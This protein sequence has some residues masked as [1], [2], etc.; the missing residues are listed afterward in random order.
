MGIKSNDKSRV[1]LK[2][3]LVLI[4]GG[5]LA[6][7]WLLS[8]YLRGYIEDRE[9]Y[10]IIR[11]TA[12]GSDNAAGSKDAATN[13]E[14][15]IDF[16]ALKKINPDTAGWLL[17]AGGEIDG[18]VV[19][20]TDDEYYLDHRFDG[21]KSSA[22]TFFADKASA[23]AF[24]TP[25][26]VVYGHNRKDGSMFHPLL[27]YKD[28]DFFEVNPCFTVITE[29][30]EKECRIISAFYSDYYDIPG[31]GE[32]E[33]DTGRIIEKAVSRSLY[34]TG[35]ESKGFDPGKDRLVILCT[36]EYSGKENR[37]VVYG[38]MSF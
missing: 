33:T 35:E 34:D 23:P 7:V 22:G 8:G 20:A 1:L 17:A 32:G 13:E 3:L 21:S 6:T 37:M 38:V 15:T 30:G 10:D 9:K 31:V 36:C 2:T 18:P 12:Y 16:D 26:T 25:C 19:Q 11:N 24:K 14:I 29:D 28:K 4:A 5:I 27:K